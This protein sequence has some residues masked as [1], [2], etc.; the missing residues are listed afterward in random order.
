MKEFQDELWVEKPKQ[1]KQ[2]SAIQKI[3]E[4]IAR[5]VSSNESNISVED[6]YEL[7]SVRTLTFESIS[8]WILKNKTSDY[9]GAFLVRMRHDADSK[10]PITVGVMF[11]KGNE[12][13]LGREHMKKIIHCTFLDSD[14]NNSFQGGESL[15]LK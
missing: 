3:K 6:R 7:E 12:V 11:L 2:S 8:A 4:R 13:A 1:N 10:F 14:L 15:I 9:D 5:L